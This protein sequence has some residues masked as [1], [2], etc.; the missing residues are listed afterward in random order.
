M[1]AVPGLRTAEFLDG[2]DIGAGGV[3][4]LKVKGCIAEHLISLANANTAAAAAGGGHSDGP[5]SGRGGTAH[6][7]SSRHLSAS[8]STSSTA[9]PPW[10]ASE[11]P[12]WGA[13]EAA[14]LA[15]LLAV[16]LAEWHD[17]G[18]PWPQHAPAGQGS[19]AAPHGQPLLELLQGDPWLLALPAWHVRHT[20]DVLSALARS[21]AA[22][23]PWWHRPSTADLFRPCLPAPAVV[24]K[25]PAL[26]TA[27]SPGELPR[28]LYGLRQVG[29][30]SH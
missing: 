28:R 16:G 2:L 19:G 11:E 5:S 25:C 6:A 20:V 12:P 3:T 15:E 13:E 23:W 7:D 21:A 17:G 1:D 30:C 24:N 27:L 29:S 9:E 18:T 4:L 10:S 22:R 8:S 26:L 14:R